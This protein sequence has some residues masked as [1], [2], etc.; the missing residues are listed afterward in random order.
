MTQSGSGIISGMWGTAHI[1]N[2]V[3]IV[4]EVTHNYLVDNYQHSNMDVT[5]ETWSV[6]VKGKWDPD[7]AL[8]D[9]ENKDIKFSGWF[10]VHNHWERVLDIIRHE[11]AHV[12]AG[13]E[14][15]HGY[16]WVQWCQKLGAIP[17]QYPS[18]VRLGNRS[19]TA[20]KLKM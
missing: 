16:E 12:L 1:R 11:C 10:L 19:L 8:T 18:N 2:K 3:D 6:W 13:Y 9:F 15:G 4:K 7:L 14:A 20:I 17:E 5:P